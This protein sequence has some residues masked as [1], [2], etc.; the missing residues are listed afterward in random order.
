[1]RFSAILETIYRLSA[2]GALAMLAYGLFVW[3]G[4]WLFRRNI[5]KA[6]DD[7]TTVVHEQP[8]KI[9]SENYKI[10]TFFFSLGMNAAGKEQNTLT[11]AQVI[12]GLLLMAA[13]AAVGVP[14][15]LALL[16]GGAAAYFGIKGAIDSHWEKTRAEIEKDVPTLL[17]NLAGV[18]QT[19]RNVLSALVAA[20]EA[21]DTQRP[22]Y[23]WVEYFAEEL[24]QRGAPALEQMQQEAYTIS[25]ALGVV[26]FEIGRMMKTGGEGYME[27]FLIAADNLSGLVDVR[28]EANTE[29]AQ[30]YSLV[31][32]IAGLAVFIYFTLLSSE[33]GR[34]ILVGSLTSQLLL[35]GSILLAIAGW[36]YI[37]TQIREVTT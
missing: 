12:V 8:V 28:A 15:L 16:G 23:A 26:V 9:G 11:M 10:R 19:E 29:A 30:A 22:L 25:S 2:A 17:R 24:R 27:A 3:L 5:D 13:M 14:L 21:I 33:G 31:R 37:R 6:L 20:M 7:F 34:E 32:A 1:M 36:N 18:L 35:A 4:Q